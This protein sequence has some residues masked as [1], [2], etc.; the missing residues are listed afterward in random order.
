MEAAFAFAQKLFGVKSPSDFVEFSTAHSREQFERLTEQTKELAA[1]AH[2]VTLATA[3]SLN[4]GI[5]K[6]FSQAL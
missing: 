1:L 4:M 3:A 6:L 5:T 2:E